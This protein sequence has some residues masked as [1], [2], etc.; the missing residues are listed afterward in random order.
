M[1]GEVKDDMVDWDQFLSISVQYLR[2][3]KVYAARFRA[4]HIKHIYEHS[5]SVHK[6]N[7]GEIKR[8]LKSID[9]CAPEI[10]RSDPFNQERAVDAEVAHQKGLSKTLSEI[11]AENTVLER[12]IAVRRDE[13][14]RANVRLKTM[15]PLK[16]QPV[17]PKISPEQQEKLKELFT[18]YSAIQRNI[19]F[20]EHHL[21]RVKNTNPTNSL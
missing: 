17:A 14:E 9:T 18:E 1:T 3:A 10:S 2:E 21:H 15:R 16:T 4:E 5:N 12:S 19:S 13:L 6:D 7:L 8:K 11:E 20:V